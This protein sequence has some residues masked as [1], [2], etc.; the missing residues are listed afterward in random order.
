MRTWILPLAAGFA[1]NA[2]AEVTFTKEIGPLL[3]EKCASCHRPGEAGPFS[4][5]TYEDASRKA[6]TIVRVVEER[7]MPP[8]HA[9]SGQV[10][11]LH[12]RRLSEDEIKMMAAWVEA[13]MPRGEGADPVPPRFPEGW[14]LGEPDIVLTMPEGY[15]VPAE[16]SDIYRNFALKLRLP[17]DK[18]VKAVELRPSARAVVHHSLFFLDNTGTSLAQDGKDGKPGFKGMGF[19][20]AGS[21]GGYVPGATVQF[22]P[23]DYAMAM[24]KNS[25]LVLAMHFHPSGKPEIEKSTVGIYLADAPPARDLANLQVPPAFGAGM[26]IN[27]PPGES[28]Y[29]VRDSFTVPVDVDA[30]SVAG[31]AHYLCREMRMTAKIPGGSEIVLLGID[32][33]DLNW[34]DRYIFEKPVRLPA[35]TVVESVLRYDNSAENP[36]NPFSPPQRVRWG[37][38]STDEMGSITLM[39]SPAPGQSREVLAE[40]AKKANFEV[41]GAIASQPREALTLALARR[42]KGLD[43]NGDGAIEAAE[44]PAIHRQR[45]MKFDRNADGRLNKEEVQGLLESFR[46]G[47]GV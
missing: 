4:L 29:V 43:V 3:H 10:P 25:D 9:V 45:A 30:L 37:H 28:N 19:R 31:H 33:W 47:E 46:T 24:P 27:I 20:R 38:E 21:L 17:E 2:S 13:G 6:K 15:P 22:L 23:A 12:D 16:G 34:Q 18:W 35:G 44:I 32:D 42:M 41:L 11:F 8:W 39:V 5:L 1:L 7:S 40:A 26:K 14:T 36:N